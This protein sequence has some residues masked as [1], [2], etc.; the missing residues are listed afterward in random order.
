M[1]IALYRLPVLPPSVP[2]GVVIRKPL[3]PEHNVVVRWVNAEFSAG[4]ASEA[5]TV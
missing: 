3:G 5:G 1:L 2:D 4:W